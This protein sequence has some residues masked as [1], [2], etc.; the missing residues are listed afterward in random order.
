MGCQQMVEGLN[1]RAKVSRGMTMEEMAEWTGRSVGR[2]RA[3]R[4][5][6]RFDMDNGFTVA[7]YIVAHRAVAK[8][9]DRR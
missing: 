6:G 1:M 9:E 7:E 4:A 3:D 8:L 5:A 2:V